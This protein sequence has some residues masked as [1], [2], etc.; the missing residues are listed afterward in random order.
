[1]SDTTAE[2]SEANASALKAWRNLSPFTL[3]VIAVVSGIACGL[4]FGEYCAPLKIAGNAYVGLLQ[5]TVLPYIVFSLVGNIGRLSIE[6]S[7]QL[8][9]VALCVLL[10]FWIIGSLVLWIIPFA[11]PPWDTGSF[12]STN[13]LSAQKE[14]DLLDLFIPSNPFHSLAQNLAPAVVLFCMFFG[15]ALIKNTN[16]EQV[17]GIFDII[18]ETLS[19]VSHMIAALAPIGIFAITAAAT[20]TLTLEEFGR[21]QA[22]LLIFTVAILII[23]LWVL[24]MLVA[25]LTPFKYLDVLIAS[26]NAVITTF[27]IGS[28]FVVI[29]MLVEAVEDLIKK[30]KKDFKEDDVRHKTGNPE[31]IIPLAYPFPHLGKVITL[32]FVPFAAWFYGRPMEFA[33]YP[34]FL[35]TGFLLNFGKVTTTIPFLLDMQELPSDIFQLFLMSSVVAGRFNDMLG[36]MHLMAFTLIVTS[37]MSGLVKFHKVRAVSALIGTVIIMAVSV[38]AIRITLDKT[39]TEAFSR[40]EIISNMN[41]MERQIPTKVFSYGAPRANSEA[42]F[43]TTLSAVRASNKL[44]IGFDPD[45]LP[46]S[47]YNAR[48]ELVGLDVDLAHRLA[49]DLGVS[50]IEFVPYTSATLTQQLAQK[51]FDIALSGLAATIARA[52]SALIS[53]PYMNVTMAF[54]VRDHDKKEFS[55]L[56]DLRSR[57]DLKIGVAIDSYFA[58]KISELLPN[59]KLVGLW[60]ESQFFEGPPEHMDALVTSAEGGAG[61]TLVKPAYTVVNPLTRQ[62]SVPLAFLIAGKD[63]DFDD[64]LK[65]WITLKTL[66]GTI[67]SLYDYWILGKGSETKQPRWSVIR[68]VLNWVD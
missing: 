57:T 45:L 50:E 38:I 25:C 51:Q 1:M 7:K 30:Y 26:R 42:S 61:W 9:I 3:I 10:L 39:F 23:M 60:S 44:R 67:A 6:E 33:D 43:Q 63:K 18:T 29:P 37:A 8:T 49:K 15:F 54:V 4:F 12:F 24:P 16:K 64:F 56:G 52:E 2:K 27:I 31:F 41:S 14:L 65:Q 59:A 48:G 66:D 68:N 13:L 21:L 20:G 55:S 5:M 40:S 34:L 11:L 36:A 62:I 22:Y 32:I 35:S 53:T 46:F 58:E 19:R 17:L 28:V 47:Y